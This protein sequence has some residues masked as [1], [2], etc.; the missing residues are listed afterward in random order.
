MTRD[1]AVERVLPRLELGADLRRAALGNR[2]AMLVQPAGPFERDVVRHRLR[3]RGHEPDGAGLCR[4]R[5][6][7]EREIGAGR[8]VVGDRL[9]GLAGRR[10]LAGLAAGDLTAVGAGPGRRG[11]ALVRRAAALLAGL[12]R[13]TGRLG[14]LRLLLAG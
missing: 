7:L 1:G 3:V 14:A 8:D 4:E 6:L 2:L 11:A 9:R 5:R 12:V 13:H 10:L